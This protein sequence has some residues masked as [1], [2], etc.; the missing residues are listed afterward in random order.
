MINYA[1]IYMQIQEEI[2][3]QNWYTPE[4]EAFSPPGEASIHVYRDNWTVDGEKGIYFE[5]FGQGEDP[6]DEPVIL[7]LLFSRHVEDRKA[8]MER[9][10]DLIELDMKPLIG[11]EIVRD[12]DV[13]MRKELPSDPL[14]LIPR[15]LEELTKLQPIAFRVDQLLGDA[16]DDEVLLGENSPPVQEETP[17]SGPTD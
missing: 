15:L 8:K 14:T 9:F 4:W 16:P 11:F 13:F 6:E 2:L 17:A 1:D 5:S 12:E 7:R 10:E 3:K